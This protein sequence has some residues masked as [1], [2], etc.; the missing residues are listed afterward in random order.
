MVP[1]AGSDKLITL[2]DYLLL[3]PA[4]YKQLTGKKLS[5]GQK[6]DLKIH[7]YFARK[8]IRTDGTVN[9]RKLYRTG[10][11]GGWQWHWGGFA[12]GLF[13]SFLGPIVALFFDDDYKWDRFWT[14]LHVAIAVA[15]I[16]LTIIAVSAGPV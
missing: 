14:A 1:L 15:L 12:L 5:F 2:E 8:A 10:L 9:L 7:K 6:I 4:S 3:T 13:L 16:A 11:F